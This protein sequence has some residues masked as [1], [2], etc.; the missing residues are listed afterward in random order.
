MERHVAGFQYENTVFEMKT[1][2]REPKKFSRILTKISE[3]PRTIRFKRTD[4][5]SYYIVR[6]NETG[7]PVAAITVLPYII[8]EPGKMY[9]KLAL[10]ID[11]FEVS[12]KYKDS[13]LGGILLNRLTEHL[14]SANAGSIKPHVYLAV[15]DADCADSLRAT[16]LWKGTSD[17]TP[18]M[19]QRIVLEFDS[20]GITPHDRTLKA[21][22][23]RGFYS[24]EHKFSTTTAVKLSPGI[25]LVG[26]SNE[27]NLQNGHNFEVAFQKNPEVYAIIKVGVSVSMSEEGCPS[28]NICYMPQPGTLLDEADNATEILADAIIEIASYYKNCYSTVTFY[29]VDQKLMKEMQRRNWN[30]REDFSMVCPD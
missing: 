13:S 18:P 15:Y 22:Q 6:E 1:L 3:I 16:E 30:L 2:T 24:L 5:H 10:I 25:I 19:Q 23:L 27:A 26:K 4:A 29:T 17:E 11:T 12:R 14:I 8:E 28:F 7:A 21:Q 20:S 9:N